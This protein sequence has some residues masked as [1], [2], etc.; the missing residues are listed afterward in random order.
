MHRCVG[1]IDC[2]CGFVCIFQ[3]CQNENSTNYFEGCDITNGFCGELP[4]TFPITQN[5]LCNTDTEYTCILPWEAGLISMIVVIILAI[6]VYAF[7]KF[8]QYYKQKKLERRSRELGNVPVD[9]LRQQMEIYVREN[10]NFEN[11]E[12]GS[13][14]SS[15]LESLPDYGEIPK[16][17]EYVETEIKSVNSVNSK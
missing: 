12:I 14:S 10:Q 5:Y 9:E 17:P 11:S 2:Y 8:S 16:V 1:D 15:S 3:C 6:V 13:K 4:T 7:W